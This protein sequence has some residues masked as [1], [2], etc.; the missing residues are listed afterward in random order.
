MAFKYNSKFSKETNDW[1]NTYVGVNAVEP[2]M[3]L[4]DRVL[5]IE[6]KMAIL[7]TNLERAE[8][9]P[10][11]KEAYESYLIIEKLIYGDNNDKKTI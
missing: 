6:K 9:F 8:K 7:N 4:H 1:S 3:D 2:V 10:A 11:L 5:A